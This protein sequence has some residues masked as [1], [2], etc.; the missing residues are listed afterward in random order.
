MIKKL[1]VLFPVFL[2][3]LI[4]LSGC[5]NKEIP[6]NESVR[7]VEVQMIQKESTPV[8]L[9]Y[10]GIV[11]ADERKGLCFKISGKI[12]EVYVKE[13]DYV[14]EGT[15]IASL[16][17]E[18]LKYQLTASQSNLN[19][20][21]LDCKKTQE[22]YIYAEDQL[23]KTQGLYEAG[24]VSKNDYEKA[25]LSM[26]TAQITMDQAEVKYQ[27]LKEEYNYKLN[28]LSDAKLIADMSG[29]ILSVNFK[30][31]DMV[32]A[33]MSIADVYNNKK[34]IVIGLTGNDLENVHVDM[35]VKISYQE[36]E[37]N[38]KVSFIG[39]VPDPVN[40]TYSV[41]ISMDDGPDIPLG[42]IVSTSFNIG[43]DRAIWIPLNAILS[44]TI[45]YVYIAQEHTAVKRNI[46]IMEVQGSR[47]RIEGLKEGDKLIIKGMK[48]IKEGNALQIVN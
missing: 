43:K 19:A 16:D 28:N 22:S 12:V 42:A 29:Y 14:K 17:R 27:Q 39:K 45:D 9:N 37:F 30:K 40:R 36:N 33:G 21:L 1:L 15:V 23:N 6:I 4:I 34:K 25:K 11:D 31:G 35:D 47:A 46:N 8:N 20:A 7:N 38:G 13:N 24:A 44:S 10:S 5:G 41:E 2:L 3:S 48:S 26:E 32:Q 18:D